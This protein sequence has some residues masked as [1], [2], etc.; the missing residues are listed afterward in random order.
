[1]INNSICVPLEKECSF[2]S[3]LR[4][5]RPYTIFYRDSL[6]AILVTQ[7][8]RGNPHFLVIPCDHR[9]TVLDLTDEE[10][11]RVS[12]LLKHLSLAIVRAY[13]SKGVSIWQNNGI[14]AS[15]SIPHVHFHIAGTL[16][17]GGTDWGHVPE[18]TL[19]ETQEI[20]NKV[21]KYFKFND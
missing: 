9:E 14:S 10:M 6:A 20:A 3:Y 15:Q 12:I 5:E 1:M 21:E 11:M 16:E 2:C 18:L 4:G 13:K 19:K 7:E 8:Q 17:E